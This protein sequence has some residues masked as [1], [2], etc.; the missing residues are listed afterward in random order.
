MDHRA[1]TAALSQSIVLIVTDKSVLVAVFAMIGFVILHVFQRKGAIY[2]Y[3]HIY[4]FCN[5][6]VWYVLSW[7]HVFWNKVMESLS[8]LRRMM[9]TNL[10]AASQWQDIEYVLQFPTLISNLS[11]KTTNYILQFCF[12]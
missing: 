11:L 4:T 2:I 9:S 8:V 3:I 10:D 1:V 6:M 5:Q 7:I 12:S